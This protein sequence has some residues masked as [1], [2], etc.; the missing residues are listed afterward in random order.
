MDPE[1]GQGAPTPCYTYGAAIAEVEVDQETGKVQV[2]D[3]T[4]CYDCGCAINPLAVEGQIEGG[5]VQGLGFTLMENM[6][7]RY[8]LAIPSAVSLKDYVVPTSMDVPRRMRSLIHESHFAMGPFGAKGVG[9]VPLNTVAPA[10]VNAIYDAVG[11]R[12][13]DLP[14]NPE[15]LLRALREQ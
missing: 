8:P 9:E 10:V 6:Y 7:P 1:T 5:L 14:V 11:V 15:V 4:A 2:L 12:I 3:L 13:K